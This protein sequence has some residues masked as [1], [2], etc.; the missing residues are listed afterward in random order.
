[1]FCL[2]CFFL[3]FPL[4]PRETESPCCPSLVLNLSVVRLIPKSQ[5][6][7]LPTSYRLPVLLDFI[8]RFLKRFIYLLYVSTL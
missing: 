7:C 1:M 2:F 6:S 8:V 5:F 3:F 4:F